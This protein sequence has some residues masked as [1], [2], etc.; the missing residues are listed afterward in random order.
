M[1]FESSLFQE[2]SL[3][4]IREIF[5]SSLG[6]PIR[7]ATLLDGGLFNTT[8]LVDYSGKKA[9]L[10]LG[11]IN[12]HLLMGFE[13]NLMEAEAWVYSVCEKIGVP[14]SRVLACDTSKTILDRDFMI[15]EYIPSVVMSRAQLGEQIRC[16]L[17]V[18]LGQYLRQ[19]HQVTN[20]SFG[21]VSRLRS[22][23]H[24]E[25]W[26]DALIYEV[27]DISGKL[28]RDGGLVPAEVAALL[29]FYEKRRELLDE[30][31]KPS[32][33]HTDLW[34]G[35]VLLTPDGTEIAAI[36]DCDRAM[37][38]DPD[39]EFSSSWM[40]NPALLEGY[41]RTETLTPARVERRKLY[42]M[43]YCLWEAYVW[44][45]EYN[46]LELFAQSKQKLLLELAQD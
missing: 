14:C 19:M 29:S 37:F 41:G 15:A 30:I 33:L 40:E 46:N 25:K 6:V 10:R 24:F 9:V 21:F 26:S 4:T 2:I 22:G 45:S 32:L 18:R 13:E 44:H 8:Y 36:I 12:R 38:G 3:D 7:E 17:N 42:R 27:K 34:E 20:Q 23:L 5:C 28:E 11:P 1:N 35:N 31:T 43:F 39:L 16:D